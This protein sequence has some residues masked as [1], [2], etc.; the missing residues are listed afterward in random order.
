MLK[1]ED[2]EK[3]ATSSNRA[4]ITRGK[5]DLDV[6]AHYARPDIFQLHMDERSK[7]AVAIHSAESRTEEELPVQDE[8]RRLARAAE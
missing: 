3:Q 7:R 5:F 4:Q 2:Q 8:A 1:P 6:V